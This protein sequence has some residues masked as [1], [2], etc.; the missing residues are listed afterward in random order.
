MRKVPIFLFLFSFFISVMIFGVTINDVAPSSDLYPYVAEMIQNNIMTL[1]SNGN[2]NGTLVITRADLARILSRLLNYIQGRVQPTAQV[3]NSSGQSN[4]TTSVKLSTELSLK[5]QKIDDAMKKYSDFEA[6]VTNTASSLNEIVSEINQLKTQL[7]AMQKL[8]ASLT[9]VK[10]IPPASVLSKTIKEVDDLS[11]KVGMM[12]YKVSKLDTS[13]GNLNS[14]M[15]SIT[16][17]FDA[18][19]SRVKADVSNLQMRIDSIVN[20][21]QKDSK[22]ISNAVSKI[23]SVSS[24]MNELSQENENLKKKVYS[25]ESTLGRIYVFQTLE[26]VAVVAATAFVLWYV[27]K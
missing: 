18:T 17:S 24:R 22:T 21:K 12:N 25:L 3:T 8:V 16:D 20:E 7:D 26:A 4:S 11:A 6:Y 10:G 5:I 2:F 14:Q 15:N 1:D 9:T 19:L 13:I 23:S 27:S